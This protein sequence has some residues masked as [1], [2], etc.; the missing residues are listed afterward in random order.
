MKQFRFLLATFA[1]A[2]LPVTLSAQVNKYYPDIWKEQPQARTTVTTADPY[3]VADHKIVYD[4]NVTN[5]DKAE[6]YANYKTI[7]K[8]IHI[9]TKMGA[10]SLLQI[11]LPLEAI[12]S[13]RGLRV[14][15][16]FP[17]GHVTNLQ[18]Q[19]RKFPM[20]DGRSAIVVNNLALQTGCDLEYELILKM[21]SDYTGAEYLQSGIAVQQVDFML[22]SPKEMQFKVVG[23]N[24]VLPGTDSTA[25]N[26]RFQL[27]SL[28]QVPALPVNDLF[29]Y[30]P[31]LQRV[32]FGLQQVVYGKDTTKRTWQLFGEAAYVPYVAVSNTEYKQLEREMARWPFMKYRLPMSQLIYQV[33]HFI[34]SNYAL[35]YYGDAYES[36]NLTDIIRN[37]EASRT[38]YVRLM[39]AAY[40][41]LNIPMHVLY[42]SSRDSIPL[43]PQLVN[44][45]MARNVLLYFPTEQ[46]ALAPLETN[47][48]YPCYPPLWSNTLALRCR[49]SLVG[50]ESKVLTDFIT[51]PSP[52]Y[53]LSNVSLDATLPSLDTPVWQITQS[54]GG[55]P[56][57]NVKAAFSKVSNET[58]RN[59]VYNA[60]L[61][62]AAG[63]R[64]PISVNASN[65]KF[66]I[67]TLEKPV[68]VTSTL[69][70]PSLVERTP[71]QINIKL[72]SLL[73]GTQHYDMD[74]PPGN[75]PVQTAFPF[76]QEK[77]VHINI[78]AG[79]K[80][81]NRDDFNAELGTANVLGYKMRCE[82]VNNQVHIFIIEWYRQTDFSNNA[83]QSFAQM[84][85]RIKV[86][87]RQELILAKE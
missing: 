68:V 17:D 66:T 3:T 55:Y 32:D 39:T 42:T 4:F 14:R 51:T 5:R 63:T 31:Q 40:Y 48:R 67:Q 56:G 1:V 35:T 71:V 18:D 13:L 80:V 9:N 44:G 19:A 74:L 82:V 70:T 53:T 77:R 16:V 36:S 85:G 69:S 11:V 33:E 45:A 28:K 8:S 7:Y 30:L 78:P 25:G 47:T 23:R 65:E 21:S 58:E 52:S 72:G 37:K 50:K 76:Y 75:L 20:T 54:F 24:G 26:I 86:L 62:F 61:P 15:A 87:Q 49:D 79:Y 46:Q 2:I 60:I 84:I 73:G 83:K 29:F 57:E 6:G 64:R 41:L 12:E 22:V 43:D 10:D 38:G 81:A 59:S 34:K 27:F